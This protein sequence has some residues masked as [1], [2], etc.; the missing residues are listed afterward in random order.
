[1]VAL[2]FTPDGDHLLSGS[3]D[4]KLRVWDLKR[5]TAR[6]TVDSYEKWLFS[7]ALSPDGTKVAT[8]GGDYKIHIY[9]LASLLDAHGECDVEPIRTLTGHTND[10]HAVSFLDDQTLVSAGDDRTV[11][12]W[13][14]ATG[15]TTNVILAHDRAIPSLASSRSRGWI[16]TG[17]RDNTVKTWDLRTGR[18]IH[19]LAHGGDVNS[20][21]FSPDAK[22]LA[23][24]SYDGMV[25]LWDP[26]SGKLHREL[27]GHQ[28]RVFT[29]AF[30]PSGRR[31]I[32]GGADGTVRMW[33]LDG[34]LLE[35]STDQ[36]LPAAIAFWRGGAATSAA[37]AT[38]LLR[39]PETL[40]IRW[41]LLPDYERVAMKP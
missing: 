15:Q 10:V 19:T 23:S 18:L 13:N 21:A 34:A 8:G 41:R 30:D 14:T 20:V 24:A 9:S 6:A 11:R 28:G 1:V 25:R 5:S 36:H 12:Y 17:S 4:G 26:A 22:Y 7:I 40:A 16:A 27:K 35:S 38:I 29:V 3:G 39:R 33:S 2:A 32:S 31:I 37:D